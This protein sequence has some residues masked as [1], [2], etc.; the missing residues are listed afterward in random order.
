MKKS[1]AS[2]LSVALS[3]STRFCVPSAKVI[4]VSAHELATLAALKAYLQQEAAVTDSLTLTQPRHLEAARRAASPHLRAMG[5]LGGNLCRC[6]TYQQHP[7]AVIAAA[8]ELK[9]DR[10]RS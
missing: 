2:S 5:T 7:P 6:G 10:S 8:G 3:S 1:Q 9:R 4:S